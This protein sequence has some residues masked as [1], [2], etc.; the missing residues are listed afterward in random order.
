MNTFAKLLVST[1]LVAALVA[2]AVSNSAGLNDSRKL[3][4]KISDFISFG[5]GSVP[6]PPPPP[7]PKPITQVI[8]LASQ[9]I[10]QGAFG[11]KP[12]PGSGPFDTL[13]NSAIKASNTGKADGTTAITGINT[14]SAAGTKGIRGTNP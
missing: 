4:Q 1:L 12:T 14:A 7:P 8:Q 9:G 3:Q 13:V 10:T 11:K 5:P 6:V 2:A